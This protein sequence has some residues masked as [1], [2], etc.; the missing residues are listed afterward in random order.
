MDFPEMNEQN[1]SIWDKNALWW[2]DKIGDG[3]DFQTILIE[4]STMKLLSIQNDDYILDIACGAGRFARLMNEKGARVLAFDHSTNFIERA[5]MRTD[6]T[7]SNIE[8]RVIDAGDSNAL[9]ELGDRMFDKAVCTMALMD[10]PSIEPLTKGLARLL[11]K[12]GTFVFSITHP[13]FHSAAITKFSEMYEDNEGRFRIN[14]GVKVTRYKLDFV[15]TTEGILGQPEPQYYFHR[16]LTSLINCF[17]KEGFVLDGIEEP[18][19]PKP[20]ERKATVKWDNMPE[21]PP[22]LVCR[23]KL[24]N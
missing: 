18:S 21:I 16:S 12:M 20:K 10:M 15:K 2:D 1:R 5:K 13:C 24:I 6:L 11:K 22:V 17:L 8:F 23:F 19:F 9:R 4:P 3:N 14:N 7:T